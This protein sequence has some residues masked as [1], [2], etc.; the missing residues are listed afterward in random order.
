LKY[1]VRVVRQSILGPGFLS[2]K[3][4]NKSW[5]PSPN[6]LYWLGIRL[7]HSQLAGC[8]TLFCTWPI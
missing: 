2:C 5:S 4:N 3:Q 1:T 7:L 6:R 8:N